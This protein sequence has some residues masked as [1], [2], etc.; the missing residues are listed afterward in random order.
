[1]PG[2][3]WLDSTRGEYWDTAALSQSSGMPGFESRLMHQRRVQVG[4][5]L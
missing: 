5:V 1:M 2:R 4:R 3:A